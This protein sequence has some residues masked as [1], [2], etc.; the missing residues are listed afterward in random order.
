MQ[1]KMDSRLRWLLR[2]TLYRFTYAT[3]TNVPIT[4]KWAYKL[5]CPFLLYISNSFSMG[6]FILTWE[7]TS[8]CVRFDIFNHIGLTLICNLCS[9]KS[10]RN[11]IFNRNNK[12]HHL[13]CTKHMLKH[14]AHKKLPNI[15]N[16]TSK[17]G[18]KICKTKANQG[19]FEIF[20]HNN[21]HCLFKHMNISKLNKIVCIINLWKAYFTIGFCQIGMYQ[22]FNKSVDFLLLTND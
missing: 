4:L 6:R 18:L 21:T 8:S 7:L 20:I 3:S 10:L 12:I 5:A 2:S 22:T 1:I 9:L 19:D 17:T 13:K 11:V 16:F 14:Y 15:V